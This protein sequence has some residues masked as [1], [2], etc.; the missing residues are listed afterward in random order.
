MKHL[1]QRTL[2]KD[3]IK[4]FVYHYGLGTY[5]AD[6]RGRNV[7]KELLALNPETVTASEVSE[8]IGN[9]HWCSERCCDECGNVTYD[10]VEIGEPPDY[11]SSTANICLDCLKK[12]VELIE[13]NKNEIL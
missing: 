8:I 5:G 3:A 7:G 1:N 13:G 11:E 10:I 12:A 4:D 6:K 2:V 9:T